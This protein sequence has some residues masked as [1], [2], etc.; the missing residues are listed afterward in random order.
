MSETISRI[1]ELRDQRQLTDVIFKVNGAEKPAHKIFLAAVSRFCEAQFLGEWG[2]LLERGATIELEDITF[3]TLS[4]MV[5]FAYTGEFVGPQLKDPK[6]SNEIA[7]ALD[8][9]LD[10]LDGTDMW[11]LKRLHDL[12]QDFLTSPPYSATFVRVDNVEAVLERCENANAARL[13]KHCQ[14]FLAIP[15]NREF[16]VA[17]RSAGE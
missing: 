3:S 13:V 15:S 9:L 17:L 5:D 10:L 11:L 12:T 16:A 6:D 14:D 4:T 8:E 1:K 2:R 7:D